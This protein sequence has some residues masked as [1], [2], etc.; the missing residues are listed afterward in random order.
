LQDAYAQAKRDADTA[1][2]VR[3]GLALLPHDAGQFDDLYDRLLDVNAGL[4]E[5]PVIR[6]ALKQQQETALAY[7]LERAVADSKEDPDRRLR[8]AC[9]LAG[10]DASE[11]GE[12]GCWQV[13]AS[14]IAQQLL[15]A[16]QNNPSHYAPLLE[17]LR[18][19]RKALFKPLAEVYRSK[20]R[21][22]S[23][24]SFATSILADYAADR[25]QLLAE[26]LMDGDAKQFSVIY[27]KFKDRGEQGLPVLTGEIDKGLPPELPSSDE[28]REQLAKRQANAA[29]ALLRMNQPAKVWP[30]LKHSPDPRV[31][32]YLIHRLSPLGAD[33]EAIIQ[34]L[35]EESDITIRRALILSLGE[36]GDKALSSDRRKAL[37]PKLQAMYRND[38]DPGVH[39][40][41]EWLLRT[42]KQEAWLKQVNDE[43]AKEKEQRQKR[44][45]GIQQIVTQHREKA[46]PRWY[47]TSQGQT[48]VVI[49]GPVEFV[50]GS[51]ET[52]TDRRAAENQH[53][54]RIKRTFALAAQAVTVE[55]YRKFNASYGKGEI[56]QYARTADSPVIGTNWFQAAAY[57]NWLSRQEGIEEEQWCYP[58][59]IKLGMTL[60]RDYLSRSGYRLPTEAEM[61]FATRAG[62]VTSRYYGETAELLEQYA[63]YQKNSQERTWPVGGKKPNDLGLFDV[64]G[65]VFSWCQERDKGYPQG[66]GQRAYDD[67]EDTLSINV[68]D[69]RVLRGG[70]F[71]L[72]AVF[73]RSAYRFWNVPTFHNIRVGFRPARTFTP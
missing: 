72:Q 18:P 62:V 49:P 3:L 42:W 19:V 60:P 58:K 5:L 53:R 61:E 12:S 30:L 44:L 63:W 27:P 20:E 7:R 34:R 33:A 46:P 4:E 6:D 57:C 41:S 71:L 29:V 8:A 23:A 14:V 25:P 66:Q 24:R 65:N 16:V 31:R 67:K 11:D 17:M 59:E 38:T 54:R 36:Y 39:A 73:V 28:G 1:Q 35:D 40:A 55:Q 15:A 52:E 69:S 56:E 47:V 50:M 37:L 48:M 26:L 70:S 2:Q 21:P 22:E 9:A 13:A 43:W 32:S 64:H 10:C 51:P 45:D 68:Q